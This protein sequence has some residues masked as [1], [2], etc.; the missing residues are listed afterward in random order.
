MSLALRRG[1]KGAN[2]IDD[3]PMA[4]RVLSVKCKNR[5]AIHKMEDELYDAELAF[6]A[7]SLHVGPLGEF[8]LPSRD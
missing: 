6:R 1:I 7:L 8:L 5:R 3:T 2:R 4:T